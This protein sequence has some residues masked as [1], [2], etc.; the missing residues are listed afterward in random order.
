MVIAD[1]SVPAVRRTAGE[2]GAGRRLVVPVPTFTESA[3]P[4]VNI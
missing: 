3:S 2:I 4:S 1:R